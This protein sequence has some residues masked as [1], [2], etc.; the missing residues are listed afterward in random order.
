MSSEKQQT[1]S[2]SA[3]DTLNSAPGSAIGDEK[4]ERQGSRSPSPIPSIRND[5]KETAVATGAELHK[6]STSAEGV[7]YPT[8]VK[9]G[10]IS[11]ALCLSV[12][13]MALDNTI[14]VSIL[15]FRCSAASWTIL[16]LLK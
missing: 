2:D 14:I 11:L 13:L 6:V 12:F 16:N 8:G 1:M 5:E 3:S 15:L 9:L 10:L 4:A 7:E